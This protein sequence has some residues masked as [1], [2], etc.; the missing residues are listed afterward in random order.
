[1]FLILVLAY[2][3]PVI[4][5]RN[6]EFIAEEPWFDFMVWGGTLVVIAYLMG[7]LYERKEATPARPA[8]EL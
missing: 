1:M 8:A 3:N 6:F 7:T 5:G 2:F 4:L